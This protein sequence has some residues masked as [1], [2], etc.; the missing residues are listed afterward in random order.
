M[1]EV[2]IRKG[3]RVRVIHLLFDAIPQIVRFTAEPADG[4][5]TAGG[6]VEVAG[7]KWLFS[8]PVVTRPLEARNAIEKGFWDTFYSIYVTPDRDVTI[9][10][11]SRHF[12]IKYL[13]WALMVVVI[14]AAISAIAV[15]LLSSP[16]GG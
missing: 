11:E 1:R 9:R 10:F 15:P 5:G 3:E 8:K 7:S 4:Q 2:A 12:H 16:G 13:L 6:T 14:L